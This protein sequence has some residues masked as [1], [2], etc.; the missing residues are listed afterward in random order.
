MVI[1]VSAERP[2]GML[3]DGIRRTMAQ[4][5]IDRK[6]FCQYRISGVRRATDHEYG[7]VSVRAW[8]IIV[9]VMCPLVPVTIRYRPPI[10]PLAP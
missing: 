8:M 1:S 3:R 6:V 2:A 10:E 4:S 7:R 5:K 9:A